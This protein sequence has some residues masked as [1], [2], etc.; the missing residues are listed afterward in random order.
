MGKYMVIWEVEKAHIPIDPKERGESYAMMMAM[1]KQDMENG[2]VKE[3]NMVV[4]ED[5]GFNIVEGTEVEISNM[6]QQ[7]VPYIN[8]EVLPL[9]TFS[10]TE[11]TVK[12][13]TG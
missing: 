12:A 10:Q 5:R 13:L 2:L 3:W 8:V 6:I 9:A 7:Y 4:G 11:E 1:T